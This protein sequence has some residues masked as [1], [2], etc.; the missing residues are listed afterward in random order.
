M[1]NEFPYPV[2][3]NY[4]LEKRWIGNTLISIRIVY[5]HQL[6]LLVSVKKKTENREKGTKPGTESNRNQDIIVGG[7]LRNWACYKFYFFSFF[8]LFFFPFF[9]S[10]F[11][12]FKVMSC[13]Y[14]ENSCAYIYILGRLLWP[15]KFEG[16]FIMFG[17]SRLRVR[18]CSCVSSSEC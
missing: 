8:V 6:S 2:Y 17:I 5:M 4:K 3:M 9:L 10:V 12:S 16:C 14:I 15:G 7:R 1:C 18:G 11:P 13:M